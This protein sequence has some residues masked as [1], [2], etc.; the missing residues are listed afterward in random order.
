MENNF[1]KQIAPEKQER[2]SKICVAIIDD[3]THIQPLSATLAT[4]RF[5][6]C[7]KV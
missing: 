4:E 5:R 3:N 2:K 1:E 6:G 7:V